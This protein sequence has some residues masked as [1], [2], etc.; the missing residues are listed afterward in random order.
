LAFLGSAAT[1]RTSADAAARASWRLWRW[2]SG[3][4]CWQ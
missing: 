3:D 4:G 2:V 1:G